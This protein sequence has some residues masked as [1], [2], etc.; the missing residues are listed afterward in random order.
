ML[1]K[2]TQLRLH[3][4]TSD[5]GDIWHDCSSSKYTSNDGIGSVLCH[6]I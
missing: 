1:V 2:K 3:H 5:R 6:V 4:F